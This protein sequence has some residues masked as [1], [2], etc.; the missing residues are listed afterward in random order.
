M[1]RFL[2]LAIIVFAL[3]FIL[4]IG[5]APAEEAE[6]VQDLPAIGQQAPLDEVEVR[7]EPEK[8]KEIVIEEP[9]VVDLD[10]KQ[11]KTGATDITEQVVTII[12]YVNCSF[13][14]EDPVGFSFKINNFEEREWVFAPLSYSE[15]TNFRNPIVQV[16]GLQ[17]TNEQLV[18]AC[19]GSRLK[20]GKSYACDFDL[21]DVGNTI[22]RKSLKKGQ[23]ISG[24]PTRNKMNIRTGDTVAEMAF[25]CE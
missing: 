10:E 8:P 22:L 25:L 3:S 16:N 6:P 11:L 20:P 21:E 14:K 17:V 4:L 5:C 19:G 12:S 18:K 24:E 9:E 2:G 7:Y 15:R 1:K 13:E 23:T